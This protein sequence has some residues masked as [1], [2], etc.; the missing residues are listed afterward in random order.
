MIHA[1]LSLSK[2]EVG[3]V[4]WALIYAANAPDQRRAVDCATAGM[5]CS[6]RLN[7]DVIRAAF[8]ILDFS[9]TLEPSQHHSASKLCEAQ[10]LGRPR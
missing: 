10:D 3:I 6:R 4:Q 9:E 2:R 1:E 5:E 7:L 8:A